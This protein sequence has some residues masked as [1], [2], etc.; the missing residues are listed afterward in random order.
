LTVRQARYALV[1]V[2]VLLPWVAAPRDG[3]GRG[4]DRVALAAG[5]AM[6][7]AR[8]TILLVTAD[9]PT[10]WPQAKRGDGLR[11][12]LVPPAGGTRVATAIPWSS[13]RSD[14]IGWSAPIA[15]HLAERGPPTLSG[16]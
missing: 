15:L 4:A 6:I 5:T 16:D 2:M 14:S 1:L 8:S 9:R 12:M 11:L 3:E 13:S 7:E 10:V